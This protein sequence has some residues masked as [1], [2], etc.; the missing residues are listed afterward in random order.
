MKKKSRIIPL[1][2]KHDLSAGKHE[3]N[4]GKRK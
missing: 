4:M 2:K 1:L 3:Q